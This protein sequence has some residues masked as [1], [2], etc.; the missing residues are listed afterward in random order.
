MIDYEINRLEEPTPEDARYLSRISKASKAH[1]GYPPEWLELWQ[2]DLEVSP[3]YLAQN[4]TFVLCLRPDRAFIGFCVICEASPELL[5]V[6]HLW[7]LPEYIGQGLGS[8]LLQRSLEECILPEHR[9]VRVV[10]DP[11]AAAFYGSRGF[12]VIDYH[13][14]QPGDRRLPVME[15]SLA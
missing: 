4:Q 7:L 15:K 5:W 2:E 1:W 11:N 14:S 6:E 10:A 8:A 3:A 9:S 12:S 13:P